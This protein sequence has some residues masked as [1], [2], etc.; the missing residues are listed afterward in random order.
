MR[1]WH[2]MVDGLHCGQ[3]AP[4]IQYYSHAMTMPRH[5]SHWLDQW[6]KRK[7]KTIIK[8]GGEENSLNIM[9]EIL[10]RY[11]ARHNTTPLRPENVE[12]WAWKVLGTAD[13]YDS[14][15]HTLDNLVIFNLTV[16]Q[17]TV[18]FPFNISRALSW[19]CSRKWL[20]VLLP[21]WMGY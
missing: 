10:P 6:R 19:F 14:W 11:E 21:P 8:A 5:L 2:T 4:Q 13:H 17:N 12:S 16:F 3:P 7:Q 1:L 15:L 20:V 18:L 9:T